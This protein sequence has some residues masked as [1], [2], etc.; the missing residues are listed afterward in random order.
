MWS[1]SARLRIPTLSSAHR[2]PWR[3]SERRA[4]PYAERAEDDPWL[5]D[6]FLLAIGERVASISGWRLRRLAYFAARVEAQES[7]LAALSDAAL[8]EAGLALRPLLLRHGLRDDFLARC[9]A[10]TREAGRRLFGKRLYRVQIMGARALVEGWLAEMATGEGKT[11][12]AAPAAIAAALA[13]LPVHVVTVNDYLAERDATQLRPLYELFGLSVGL[14]LHGQSPRERR[15]AYAADITYGANKEI[16]FDYLRDR[17]ALG[18]R[19]SRAARAVADLVG[20]RVG[21]EPLLLRGLGFAIVDEAD[22]VL[23]DEARTPLIISADGGEAG[24]NAAYTAALEIAS[25]LAAD[26]HFKVSASRRVVR[27]T[28]QGRARAEA[29]ARLRS[30]LLAVRRAREELVEQ[31]LAALHLFKR[32]HHYVV[33]EGEVRIVDEQTGRIAEGRSWE[34]GLHQLIETKEGLAATAR[35]RTLARITYQRFFRR[36]LRLSGMTGTAT[37]VAAELRAVYGLAVV[38]IPTNRPCLR[39]DLGARLVADQEAKW[40]AVAERARSLLA[41]G[42]PVLVGTRSIAASERL[43][44]VLAAAGVP[45]R[46]L[47]AR[48]DREEADIVARA[49]ERGALTVATNMA[50][51]GT[52]I[53]LGP[54]VAATGGLHV[55]VTEYHESRRIDRQLVGRAARQGDPGSFEAIVAA[56]DELFR[57]FAG[58][59]L[60]RLVQWAPCR[61]LALRLLRRVAQTRAEA[62]AAAARRQTML[63]DREIRR[64][65]GF[66]G[67]PE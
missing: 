18:G 56:D 30:G 43:S 11:L 6:R 65:L 34:R 29:L 8:R 46:V 44:A 45:H 21:G 3:S 57:L 27:L 36:Y 15:E 60:T 35:R 14:C 61:G 58:P 52:D 26:E 39:R 42:R 28:E 7:A 9:F 37:E 33:A 59:A 51:R 66:A 31:A 48:F 64:F 41:E 13:G 38:R 32:D 23:I 47:N 19:R 20:G 63:A 49:G 62:Q 22:S 54:G 10:L 55:I 53:A 67:R 5:V 1:A 12:T 25:R 16:A 24:D 50:G 2:K 40:Q 4:G 17:I